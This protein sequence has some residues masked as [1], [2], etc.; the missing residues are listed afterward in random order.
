MAVSLE[1]RVPFLDHRVAALAAR[2]PLDMKIRGETGKHVLRKLLYRHAPRQ[3]IERPK[4][5]F[6]IPVG[7]WIKGPLRDWAESLLESARLRDEGWLDAGKIERRWRQHLS[8]ERDSTGA[9]WAVLMFEAW[10]QN[11]DTVR[12]AA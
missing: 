8:G 11:E 6:A 10:L 5:G 7:D 12:L 2:I 4:S 1:S 9:L 3:L